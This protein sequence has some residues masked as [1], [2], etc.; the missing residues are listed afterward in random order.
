MSKYT[1]SAEVDNYLLNRLKQEYERLPKAYYAS[2]F[3]TPEINSIAIGNAFY[4]LSS[5]GVISVTKTMYG[6]TV[7]W[8]VT[9]INTV[10]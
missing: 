7:I 4:R 9:R 8:T 6:H 5:T 3:A 1:R 2:E 10:L